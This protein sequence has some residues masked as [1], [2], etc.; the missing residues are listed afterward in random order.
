MPAGDQAVRGLARLCL[1]SACSCRLRHPV[2]GSVDPRH[3]SLARGGAAPVD[4]VQ[5]L[6]RL[7]GLGR[8]VSAAGG[9]AGGVIAG[10]AP[11][12]GASLPLEPAFTHLTVEELLSPMI[13]EPTV[14]VEQLEVFAD[15]L[16]VGRA[17]EIY[18]EHGCLVV[19]GLVKPYLAELQRDIEAS[20]AQALSLL[21]RAK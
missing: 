21:D 6:T 13:T 10:G 19:R 12:H 16:D 8:R 20:A 18:K 4:P 14:T 9:V 2:H 7:P 1:S 5:V 3:A 15:N 11:G 17:A